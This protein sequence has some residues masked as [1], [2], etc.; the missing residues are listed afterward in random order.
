MSRRSGQGEEEEE[1]K[2]V[3]AGSRERMAEAWLAWVAR[4]TWSN[5]SVVGSGEDGEEKEIWEESGEVG[6]GEIEVMV[7]DRW[8]ADGWKGAERRATTTWTP[9]AVT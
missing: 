9:V 5:V 3:V 6:E 2:E 1:G 7:A 8:M 4:M